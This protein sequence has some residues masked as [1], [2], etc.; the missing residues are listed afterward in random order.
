VA[1]EQFAAIVMSL[2][3]ISP[4]FTE[5]HFLEIIKKKGGTRLVSWQFEGQGNKKG[6]AY[7]SETFRVLVRGSTE[8]K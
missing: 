3:T 1:Q 4:N 7:L 8:K 2:E 6:D 5:E